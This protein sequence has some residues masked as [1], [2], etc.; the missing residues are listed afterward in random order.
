MGG[1]RGLVLAASAAVMVGPGC[2]D[3]SLSE[4]ETCSAGGD[5]Q[6][7]FHD[8]A[9]RAAKTEMSESFGIPGSPLGVPTRN[10]HGAREVFDC[11]EGGSA[12]EAVESAVT[13]TRRVLW[14]IEMVANRTES[15]VLPGGGA[16]ACNKAT[17]SLPAFGD[18]ENASHRNAD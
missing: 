10:E 7:Y 12:D 6:V 17:E 18:L 9:V 15:I 1:L 4:P 3:E 13:S 14:G 8:A 2:K 5:F 11:A 16:V